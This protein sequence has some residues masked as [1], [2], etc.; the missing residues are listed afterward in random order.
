MNR[1]AEKE[2]AVDWVRGRRLTAVKPQI[3]P[4]RPTADRVRCAP[5]LRV[6]RT[7]NPEVRQM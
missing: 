1:G 4:V 7:P 3:M 2:M 6:R 5:G